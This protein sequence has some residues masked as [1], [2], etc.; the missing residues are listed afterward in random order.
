MKIRAL[1]Y[2]FFAGIIVAGCGASGQEIDKDASAK[3]VVNAQMARQIFDGAGG[4]FESV[5]EAD[6]AKLKEAYGG[7]AGVEKLWAS[8]TNPPVGGGA[9]TPS[10][11]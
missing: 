2:M 8:M 11:Q 10:G 3:A 4:K 1:I 7:D 5:S 6:K 9:P